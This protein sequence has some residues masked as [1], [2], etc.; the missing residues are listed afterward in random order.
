MEYLQ[1]KEYF[2]FVTVIINDSLQITLVE[3]KN[4]NK[5]QVSF[6]IFLISLLVATAII[7]NSMKLDIFLINIPFEQGEDVTKRCQWTP[8]IRSIHRMAQLYVQ[9]YEYLLHKIVSS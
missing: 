9:I 6:G 5:C 7:L 3:K 4:K 2:P 8:N 1:D